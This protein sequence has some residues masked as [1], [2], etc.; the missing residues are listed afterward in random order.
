MME[1]LAARFLPQFIAIART[2]VAA[3]TRAALG[4]DDTAATTMM[5]E[6]HA[7]AGEAGLLGLRDVIPLA[8]DCEHR[9]KE[10]RAASAGGDGDG[11]AEAL[12]EALIEALRRL[13]RAIDSLAVAAPQT[14]GST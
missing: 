10:L 2:R 4:R 3:A 6:L 5:R 7:L 9:A 13:E 14:A 12:T 8:R 1:E 11:R